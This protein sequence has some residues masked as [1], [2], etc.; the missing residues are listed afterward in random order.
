MYDVKPFQPLYGP[1]SGPNAGNFV[2][3]L[4]ISASTTA[5]SGAL[6][7]NTQ[8]NDF[9][10]LQIANT[11]TGW[12]YVNCGRDKNEISPATVAA[13][14]PVAPGGVAVITVPSEVAAVSVILGSSSGTVI[15]TRGTGS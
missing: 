6:P 11:T 12:A 1:N 14:Y 10:Q 3:S 7:G 9:C 15:F 13:G 4:T 5:T 8:Q 2:S